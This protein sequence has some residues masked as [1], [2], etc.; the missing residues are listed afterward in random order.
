MIAVLWNKQMSDCLCLKLRLQFQPHL[1]QK[2]STFQQLLSWSRN[3]DQDWPP[4]F[5]FLTSW[6]CTH[7]FSTHQRS[8]PN[9]TTHTHRISITCTG[10]WQETSSSSWHLATLAQF[11]FWV[12]M[13]LTTPCFVSLTCSK[14]CS[15]LSFNW[16]GRFAWFCRSMENSAAISI[17]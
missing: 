12:A 3:A 4:I 14:L 9:F 8:L 10:T 1:L 13:F 16:L 17:T 5:H 6:L 7:W 11:H 2:W 15:C